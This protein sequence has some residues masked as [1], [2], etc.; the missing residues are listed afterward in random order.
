[1]RSAA[2]SVR[3]PGFSLTGPSVRA[4][5]TGAPHLE[6]DAAPSDPYTGGMS[7]P[8]PTVPSR[9]AALL[10]MAAWCSAPTA[11]QSLP[12]QP[13]GKSATSPAASPS[14]PADGAHGVDEAR[15]PQDAPVAAR[16][17]WPAEA[18]VR[19]RQNMLGVRFV[20]A[21]GWHLYWPGQNDSGLPVSLEPEVPAGL[22]VGAPLWPAPERHVAPGDVLDHVV[23]D[24]LLL[25]LPVHVP[26]DAPLGDATLR[27]RVDWVVCREACLM[28][29]ADLQ[30]TLP[31]VDEDDRPAARAA[32]AERI[33]AARA[34][35]PG[36]PP[37]DL[38][39][40]RDGEHIV[41][42]VPRAKSLQFFPAE[43]GLPLADILA[44][45]VASGDTL[46]LRPDLRRR[47]PS[48]LRGV[49]AITAGDG[50]ILTVHIDRAVP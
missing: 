44:T 39:L 11:G 14:A 19:G 38:T 10:L 26:A 23:H 50:P 20:L 33:A 13:L 8:R 18:L 15:P 40:A 24:T 7:M 45:C 36:P 29:G 21:E 41:L 6:H 25:L 12:L 16:L 27:L 37:S 2:G 46:R 1:M 30:L 48:R 22:Q 43:D 17:L 3:P 4:P 9:L 28:D 5:A 34:A 35:L 47:G 32:D 42:R 49:L 31:V